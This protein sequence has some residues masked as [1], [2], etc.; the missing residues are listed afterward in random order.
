MS[1]LIT[2][3]EVSN[4]LQVL[5]CNTLTLNTDTW[6]LAST[7]LLYWWSGNN[8]GIVVKS[9]VY[10]DIGT[11]KKKWK[12]MEATGRNTLQLLEGSFISSR[13]CSYRVLVYLLSYILHQRARCF[14]P[15]IEVLLNCVVI[16]NRMWVAQVYPQIY[17]TLTLW[18]TIVQNTIQREY[19]CTQSTPET[20]IYKYKASKA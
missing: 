15:T 11:C 5:I 7:V 16:K 13:T 10:I 3:V 2:A 4:L 8:V 9:R 12:C 14:L 18:C 6:I 17:T 1:T 19:Q 20:D